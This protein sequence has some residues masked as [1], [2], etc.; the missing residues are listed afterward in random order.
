MTYFCGYHKEAKEFLLDT[1]T[2]DR[3]LTLQL[4]ERHYGEDW[5]MDENF[6]VEKVSLNLT[7]DKP[8]SK[9][10]YKKDLEFIKQCGNIAQKNKEIVESNGG[11]Y[12]DKR[13][14]DFNYTAYANALKR[15]QSKGLFYEVY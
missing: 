1:L 12:T 5:S 14:K 3:E 13:I 8:L 10:S 9:D 6:S 11:D 15:V 2:G 4:M 7:E